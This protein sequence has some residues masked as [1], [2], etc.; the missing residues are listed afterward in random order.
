MEPG[1][2]QSLQPESGGVYRLPSLFFDR[3]QEPLHSPSLF[4][5][6]EVIPAPVSQPYSVPTIGTSE[7]SGSVGLYSH[8]IKPF[9]QEP[10]GQPEEWHAQ[11]H[12]SFPSLFLEQE[13]SLPC[14]S[15]LQAAEP[16]YSQA[17]EPFYSQ[18]ADEVRIF[19]PSTFSVPKGIDKPKRKQRAS[20]QPWQLQQLEDSFRVNPK[21]T[22]AVL[23]PLAETLGLE[24][25]VVRIW[26]QNHR[27]KV[28]K[29]P[30]EPNP[31]PAAV[32]IIPPGATKLEANRWRLVIPRPS[33]S[34]EN[35]SYIWESGSSYVKPEAESQATGA[36][37]SSKSS[38]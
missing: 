31:N 33:S 2:S 37:V 7:S 15:G 38:Q 29:K 21:P 22:T 30:K 13:L 18:A 5:G 9:F 24:L 35:T 25:R 27:A 16:F 12:S 23:E 26:F 19:Q 3:E 1:R 34:G 17:A 8:T 6:R 10:G 36:I 28:K 32:R 20:L 4:S 14:S 11:G